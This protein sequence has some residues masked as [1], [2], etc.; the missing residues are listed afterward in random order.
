MNKLEEMRQ[1]WVET[2]TC[3]KCPLH[4]FARTHV[5]GDGNVNAKVALVGEAPGMDEDACGHPFMGSAG[6][7]LDR[8]LEM[9]GLKRREL[10]I[11][12]VLVCHPPKEIVMGAGRGNRAPT[13]AEISN[14]K[15]R[16]HKQLHIVN[17]KVIVALGGTAL[18]VLAN[19]KIPTE[20]DPGTVYSITAC[21][22]RYWLL[23]N[24]PTWGL[25][26]DA[27]LVAT[28]H[29]QYLG[30]HSDDDTATKFNRVFHKIKE[31]IS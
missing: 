12:N 28:F 24:H 17:P 27:V 6:R 23:K 18:S 21:I 11:C 8:S 2:R 29:P 14:C 22:A 31:L 10:F 20:N 13:P 5:F 7:I 3:K 19:P 1:L 16:L 9:A 4:V 26:S 15:E 25:P 30:Y